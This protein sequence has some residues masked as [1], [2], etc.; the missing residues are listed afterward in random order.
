MTTGGAHIINFVH[1]R[2]PM[3]AEWL[4]FPSEGATQKGFPE[5]AVSIAPRQV[6]SRHGEIRNR[7]NIGCNL[8]SSKRI[9][10]R[11]EVRLTF[12]WGI[13]G[14]DQH[15]CRSCVEVDGRKQRRSCSVKQLV[16]NRVIKVINPQ[17]SMQIL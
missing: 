2:T 4:V 5:F 6:K 17:E 10:E 7:D 15:Y 1:A 12:H 11:R 16:A 3:P 8:I 14:M 9:A 13:E